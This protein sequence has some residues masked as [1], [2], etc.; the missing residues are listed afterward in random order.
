M[1][2]EKVYELA[3]G[4]VWSG[5][6]ALKNGLVD[7]LGGL[8]RAIELAAEEAGIENYRVR[9][10]PYMK[11]PLTEILEQITGRSISAQ[12]IME[13]EIP[14]IRDVR[15]IIQGGRIQTRLPYSITIR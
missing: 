15:E 4:R 2:I 9:E 5:T 7:E 8:S 11:D 6:D 10:L 3:E 13:T 12:K 1:D 14:A